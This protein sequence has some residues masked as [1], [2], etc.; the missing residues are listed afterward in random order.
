M[1]YAISSHFIARVRERAPWLLDLEQLQ[2]AIEQSQLI[3]PP[4]NI[5]KKIDDANARTRYLR[6]PSQSKLH[7]A[8]ILVVADDK[9]VTLYP[10]DKFDQAQPL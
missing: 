5:Y 4:R 8:L 3:D 10:A 1:I 6:V 9:L 7:S 2:D